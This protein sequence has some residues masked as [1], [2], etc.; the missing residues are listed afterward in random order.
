MTG[1]SLVY[2]FAH[3]KHHAATESDTESGNPVRVNHIHELSVTGVQPRIRGQ[4]FWKKW[5][6]VKE[7]RTRRIHGRDTIQHSPR[8]GGGLNGFS[9]PVRPEVLLQ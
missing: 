9:G 7:Q 2:L 4:S 3:L 6:V 1:N 8:L 5:H